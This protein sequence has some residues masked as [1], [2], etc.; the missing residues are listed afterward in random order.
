[1]VERQLPVSMSQ[2]HQPH[3]SF[4]LN[5][6]LFISPIS[7][8]PLLNTPQWLPVP[9]SL[10]HQTSWRSFNVLHDLTS[11]DLVSYVDSCSHYSNYTILFYFSKCLWLCAST[12]YLPSLCLLLITHNLG[13]ICHL[14]QLMSLLHPEFGSLPCP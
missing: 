5:S 12:R 3:S 1:M 4:S 7:F 6:I 11:A 13:P 14:V 8:P 10:D 2:H 9:L